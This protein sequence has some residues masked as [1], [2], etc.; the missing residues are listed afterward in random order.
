MTKKK[1]ISQAAATAIAAGLASA[2]V[3]PAAQA[4]AAST[5]VPLPLAQYAHMV[6]DPTHQHLFISGGA[7]STGILVTDYAGQTVATIPDETNANGL[8]L[9][10]D[11][12]TVYAALG[13]TDAVSAISTGTLT[14]TARYDTGSG[15]DPE[16][17]AWSA[18]KI[19]FGYSGAAASSGIGSIEPAASATSPAVVTLKATGDTWY[20]APLLAATAGGELIAG[21]P[22]QSPAELGSYDVSSGTAQLLSRRLLI[23]GS[24]VSS[25]L[26]DL[27]ITPDGKDVVTA[28]G[29][30]YQHQVFKVADLTP[31]GHYNSTDYP[32]SVALSADGTVFAGSN[33]YYGDSVFVFAPGNPNSLTS[34]TPGLDTWQPPAGLAVTPD[35]AELFAISTDDYLGSPTLHIYQNPAQTAAGLTLTGPARVQPHAAVTLSGSLSGPAPY[36]GGQTVHVTRFDPAHPAGVA[37]PAVTTAA[38]GSFS[39]TDTPRGIGTVTYQVSYDGGVHLASAGATATV[40]IGN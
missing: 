25:T 30:P 24:Q 11:G 31:D 21:E 19:W 17:V 13:S 3:L 4:E 37:L 5:S 29:A 10:P 32:S 35:G 39:V 28:C 26:G 36:T 27:A 15:A 18:G 9:S 6:L 40:Q 16:S 7:G 20:G 2:V 34:F 12:S 38:D 14:E 1:L 22:G 33:D 23:D 8:A